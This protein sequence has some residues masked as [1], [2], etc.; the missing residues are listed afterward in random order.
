M[1]SDWSVAS[2]KPARAPSSGLVRRL[3]SWRTDRPG[4]AQDDQR[5]SRGTS[6]VPF[7]QPR[8][9]GAPSR[10]D[11]RRRFPAEAVIGAGAPWPRENPPAQVH[12]TDNGA[13]RIRLDSRVR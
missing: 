9:A 7:G 10:R 11:R 6:S 4:I 12:Q 13:P 3:R 1:D 2:R 8:S 5:A